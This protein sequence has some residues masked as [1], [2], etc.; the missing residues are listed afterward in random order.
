M[1]IHFQPIDI[2]FADTNFGTDLGV[3]DGN[4]GRIDAHHD[5][6]ARSERLHGVDD[7]AQRPGKSSGFVWKGWKCRERREAFLQQHQQVREFSSAICLVGLPWQVHDLL[8]NQ[9]VFH[10]QISTF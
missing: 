5:A 8:Q 3:Q 7:I 2:E 10:H 6:F 9:I 4:P 1:Q